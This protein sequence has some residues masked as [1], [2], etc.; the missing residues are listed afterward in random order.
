MLG[1]MSDADERPAA[2]FAAIALT[3]DA[4]EDELESL[5]PV[6]QDAWNYC[7]HRALPDRCPA[8][9]MAALTV[10]RKARRPTQSG[11][12]ARIT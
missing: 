8:E 2:G 1:N 3:R 5:T 10:E 6:I 4:G 12:G 11:T 7:P 9:I